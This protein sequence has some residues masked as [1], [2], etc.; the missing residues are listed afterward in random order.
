MR[1]LL[2][3]IVLAGTAAA[4]QL[5]ATPSIAVVD[6]N[7]LDVLNIVFPATHDYRNALNFIPGV[8]QD[9]YGQTHIA[10]AQTYQTQTLLDGF[11]VTQPA[12]G[13]LLIRV[14]IDAFRSIQVEP[15]REPAEA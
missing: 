6:E 3:T 9:Q 7:G 8:V 2:L 12:N 11:N 1:A 4:A 10:R 15:T 5:P 14:S 13:Q